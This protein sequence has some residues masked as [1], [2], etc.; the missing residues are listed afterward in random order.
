MIK[1]M[2]FNQIK[3]QPVCC[4]HVYSSEPFQYVS[5]ELLS[6][7]QDEE[8][9]DLEAVAELER[10]AKGGSDNNTAEEENEV[11]KQK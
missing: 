3:L 9:E 7:D 5:W 6:V 1:Y 11:S 2:K 10:A 8:A 4:W